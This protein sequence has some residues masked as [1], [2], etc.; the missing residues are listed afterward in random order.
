[1]CVMVREKSGYHLVTARKHVPLP[2]QLRALQSPHK[3]PRRPIHLPYRRTSRRARR[4][5]DPSKKTQS[6]PV[7]PMRNMQLCMTRNVRV[8]LREWGRVKA[9]DDL[10]K[11]RNQIERTI[12]GKKKEKKRIGG[13]ED[14]MS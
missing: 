14:S 6:C 11:K 7:I 12:G 4:P 3:M 5:N 1:M 13:K 2:L 10:K 9:I 8:Y